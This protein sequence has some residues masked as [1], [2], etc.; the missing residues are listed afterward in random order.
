M[1]NKFLK[2][3]VASLVLA[4]SGIA[5]AGLI[6]EYDFD[7]LAGTANSRNAILVETGYTA[8][9]LAYNGTVSGNFGD[10]FYTSDWDTTF[11]DSKYYSLTISASE[12]SN[13]D[14]LLFSMETTGNFGNSDFLKIATSADGFSTSLVE[15]LWTTLGTNEQVGDGGPIFNFDFSFDEIVFQTPLEIRFYVASPY[16]SGFANHDNEPSRFGTDWN[17]WGS[18]AGGDLLIFA[19]AAEVPEPST[20][21]V[22][23]LGVMGLASRRFKKQA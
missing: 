15:G 4:V 5:N 2:G 16:T 13:L 8:S 3:L 20:L 10:H 6:V 17:N 18:V 12:L 22:F 7:S 11:N 14:R 19:S 9:P 1:R 23:A 21:A